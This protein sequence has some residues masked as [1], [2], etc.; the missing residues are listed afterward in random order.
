MLISMITKEDFDNAV[1]TIILYKKQL[2]EESKKTNSIIKALNI[3]QLNI[4]NN[5][6]ITETNLSKRTQNILRDNLEFLTGRNDLFWK[7]SDCRV[8][9]LDFKK[10]RRERFLELGKNGLKA[11][12]ELKALIK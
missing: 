1:E 2:V 3:I 10:V 6:L 7:G 12:K 11:F 8:K 4:N 9:L 5:T